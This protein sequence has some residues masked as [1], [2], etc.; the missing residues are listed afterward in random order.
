[1]T[2]G[3]FPTEHLASTGKIRVALSVNYFR[4]AHA[5]WPKKDAPK[6]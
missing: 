1:M 3:H 4:C 5:F 2:Y 6:D